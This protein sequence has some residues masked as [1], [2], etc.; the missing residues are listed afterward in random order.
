[1]SYKKAKEK[2][3]ELKKKTAEEK[4]SDDKKTEDLKEKTEEKSLSTTDSNLPVPKEVSDF[5]KANASLGSKEVTASKMASLKVIESN[6]KIELAD[7]T[8]PPVGKF[9]Y[10]R[11]DDSDLE[12]QVLENPQVHLLA[13]SRGF[14]LP[15]LES[16]KPPKY[17]QIVSGVLADDFK[18][19]ITY[20][21][22]KRLAP[23]WEWAREDLAKFTKSK[24][25]IPMFALRVKLGTT[26]VK[27]PEYKSESH[28][29]D[30]EIMK[31]EED[32]SPILV[33]DIET[34]EL[35]K[36]GLETAEEM[37]ERF[38]SS[39]QVA[40]DGSPMVTAADFAPKE[41]TESEEVDV[42]DI[43]F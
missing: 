10:R 31:H 4:E 40:K 28:I 36:R 13:I 17:H 14:Y 20:I 26:V 38:I 18:P 32:G 27:N 16:G 37:F 2:A 1:M 19:F 34:L 12:E 9:Y 7:G 25:P 24:D 42:D 11:E 30:F 41:N 21:A 43:P 3:E 33:E 8:R 23:M 39:K 15:S 6:S 35:L 29:I 5:Y 22:G